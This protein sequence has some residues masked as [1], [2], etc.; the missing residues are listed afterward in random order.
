[1]TITF[2]LAPLRPAGRDIEIA[3]T[4]G[5]IRVNQ[6]LGRLHPATSGDMRRYGGDIKREVVAAA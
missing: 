5:Y 1:M 2:S 4:S 3:A 6:G